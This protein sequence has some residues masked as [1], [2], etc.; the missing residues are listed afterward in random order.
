MKAEIAGLATTLLVWGGLGLGLATP[1]AQ[2]DP[3]CPSGKACMQWCP[4]QP[5]PAGR[6]VPWDTSVCHDYFW[7]NVGVHD[8]G[9]GAFY[10]WNAMPWK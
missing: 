3:I 6:P 7:D 9:T 10:A 8:T 2:A 1:A 5:N 4:G